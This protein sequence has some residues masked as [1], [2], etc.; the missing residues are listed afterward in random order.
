[1]AKGRP[2]L[3]GA[4]YACGKLREPG[5]VPA[6]DVVI[7]RQAHFAKHFGGKVSGDTY[8]PIGRA[9]A[10]CLLEGTPYDPA[11][12]RDV[13]RRYAAMHASV[14]APTQVRVWTAERRSPRGNTKHDPIE[15]DKLGERF[16]ALDRLAK[17]AGSKSYLAM[18]KLVLHDNPDTNPLWLERLINA[19]VSDKNQAE[20][21]DIWIMK[22]ALS[23]LQ[24]MVEG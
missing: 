13:G 23:A 2:K 5:R 19:R 6:N 3:A 12:L 11:L 10:A 14:Y 7:A 24:F 15:P 1:M 18:K 9:W 22:C 20:E 8:D 21:R 4:R 17:N 16:E